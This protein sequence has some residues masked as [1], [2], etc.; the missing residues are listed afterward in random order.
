MSNEVVEFR[1][2]EN[3]V[4][5]EVLKDT[6]DEFLCGEVKK[7]A[8]VAEVNRTTENSSE[9]HYYDNNGAIVV[10][11]VGADT[12][13]CSVSAIP[14]KT[15]AEITGQYW[16][17]ELGVLVEGE[18]QSKYFA[19]GYK[20][21]DTSGADVYVWRLK[22]KFSIPDST[23]STK[24]AGTEA[25][26]QEITYTGISTTYKLQK[27]GRVAKSTV[28][29]TSESSADVFD[30]FDNVKTLD[31]LRGKMPADIVTTMNPLKNVLGKRAEMLVGNDVRIM[32]DGTVLGTIK[33]VTNYTGFSGKTEE[34][35]GH[36]FPFLLNKKGSTMSI[37]GGTT[38][39]ENIPYDPEIVLKVDKSKKF[40]IE[41]DGQFVVELKFDQA[42]LEV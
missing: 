28:V 16:D 31:D 17:E 11:S 41:V 21:S 25:N 2:V 23:H 36:F 27:T 37:K 26:G 38:P 13:T 1:G 19:L 4:Y 14:M 12:V 32:A 29:K 5:A 24:T 8:G 10:E 7:L 18:R 33:N 39:K 22:G 20:A 3:L 15:V 6:V 42:T 35:N 30:F 34:Q 9:T 40:T